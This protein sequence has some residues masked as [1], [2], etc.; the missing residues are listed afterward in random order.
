[1]SDRPELVTKSDENALTDDAGRL[2]RAWPS[3]RAKPLDR[4]R[5]GALAVAIVLPGSAFDPAEVTK[6]CAARR[7]CAASINVAFNFRLYCR[8]RLS[9]EHM[10]SFSLSTMGLSGVSSF[11]LR[12][13]LAAPI[14]P[15]VPGPRSGC[16]MSFVCC[17]RRFAT[18]II[19]SVPGSHRLP[20]WDELRMR[21]RRGLISRRTIWVGDPF[22]PE[23]GHK[24]FSALLSSAMERQF[25]RNGKSV[26]SMQQYRCRL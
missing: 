3:R 9:G 8:T 15:V 17:P 26:P 1:V 12:F 5:E 18:L 25:V 21:R 16:S 22:R 7:W 10:I 4:V 24:R 11:V 14:D 19:P 23:L 13:R 20:R 2:T 6:I